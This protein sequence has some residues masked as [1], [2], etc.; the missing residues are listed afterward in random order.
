MSE[1]LYKGITTKKL[2]NG[3]LAIMVRFKYLGKTY[4]VKNFTKL[5]GSQTQEEAFEK[6]QEIKFELLE[7][8]DPFHTDTKDL[9]YYFYEKYQTNITN[10][11]WKENTTAKVYLNYYKK[12]IEKE[13]GQKKIVKITSKDIEKIIKT[14]EKKQAT[15]FHQLK[16]ILNPIFN[17]AIQRGEI[18]INPMPKINKPIQK[19]KKDLENRV[20]DKPLIVIQKLYKA[21]SLYKPKKDLQTELSNYLYLLILTAHRY[22]ELLQLTKKDIDLDK[23]IIIAPKNITKTKETYIFPIPNEV[24][25]F[26]EQIDDG[27]IFKNLKYS[28]VADYFKKLVS[29]AHIHTIDQK[30]I[31]TNDI[32]TMMF[33]IMVQDAKIESRLAEECLDQK[34]DHKLNFKYEEKEK[35]FQTYWKIIRN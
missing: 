11:L 7:G 21:V 26:L 20:A 8:N 6:L 4:P 30:T 1:K 10:G 23:K 35:A 15:M 22:G 17:E 25:P 33:Q 14:L 5:F 24:L 29:L 28:S 27:K 34:T 18:K 32:R 31:T 3:E 13:L 2:K 12:Y 16:K 9:N 19:I